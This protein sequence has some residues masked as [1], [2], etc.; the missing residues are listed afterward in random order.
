MG[1]RGVARRA[2]VSAHAASSRVLAVPAVPAAGVHSVDALTSARRCV[3]PFRSL[4]CAH[5][6]RESGSRSRRPRGAIRLRRAGARARRRW[7]VARAA[8][9]G[10]RRRGGTTLPRANRARKSALCTRAERGQRRSAPDA[11]RGR[12]RPSS[13]TEHSK[14]QKVK[15]FSNVKTAASLLAPL[16]P[17][18]LDDR[19]QRITS[20]FSA[21]SS[22][23]EHSAGLALWQSHPLEGRALWEANKKERQRARCCLDHCCLASWLRA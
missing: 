8:G 18:E 15:T 6:E 21:L 20:A 1:R 7:G 16:P 9:A 12:S 2:C 5:S 22:S 14:V 4:R 3:R 10:R 11:E 13:R 19:S 23:E 17:K